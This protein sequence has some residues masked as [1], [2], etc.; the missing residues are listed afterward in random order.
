VPP[1][2]NGIPSDLAARFGG[3]SITK[4]TRHGTQ[5]HGS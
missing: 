4:E 3:Q 5:Y 1:S 2:R